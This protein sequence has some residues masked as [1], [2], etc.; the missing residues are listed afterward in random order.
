MPAA[1]E[2]QVV[3]NRFYRIR[4]VPGGIAGLFDK[5]LG[6]EVL[7]TGK[8]L[9]F[10]VFTMRSVGNGAGEFGRVQQPTMEGFD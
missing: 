4:L 1:A 10:E 2:P 8:F 7:D 6:R 9:G 5:E 3:E